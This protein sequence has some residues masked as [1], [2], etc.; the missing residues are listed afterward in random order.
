MRLLHTTERLSFAYLREGDAGV[1]DTVYSDPRVARFVDDGQPITAAE[2]DAWIEITLNNYASRGYGMFSLHRK[3][4]GE[5]VG[6][7]GIVHPNGQTA[8]EIKY[9]L[10]PAVWG[11]GLATEA[12]TGVIEYG[13]TEHGLQNYV[14][15]VDPRN[16]A[17][18]NVLL[19]SGFSQGD[20]I[21]E[22]DGSEVLVFYYGDSAICEQ[23]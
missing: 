4:S 14:A 16:V 12:V 8:P 1:F 9:A 19:K 6:C 13:M 11:E 10:L 5:L 15:T 20:S 18:Q 23:M 17:S 22:D 21:L 2:C 3:S 7:I